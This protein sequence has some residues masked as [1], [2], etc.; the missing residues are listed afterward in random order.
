MVKIKD[1]DIEEIFLGVLQEDNNNK[2]EINKKTRYF[3]DSDW[4]VLSDL[5]VENGLF[6]VFYKR[7]LSLDLENTPPGL[8]SKLKTLYLVNLKRNIILERELFDIISYLQ[9]NNIPVIPLKGPTLAKFLYDDLSLRV[10]SCDLDLLIEQSKIKTAQKRLADKGYYFDPR[11]ETADFSYRFRRQIVLQRKIE[12]GGHMFLDLHWDFR[13]QFSHTHLQDFWLNAVNI[14]FDG[15][16]I[17]MPSP[18]DLL[19]YLILISISDFD[20]IQIKYLYDTHRLVTS[21]A[22]HI[23]WDALAVKANQAGLDTALFF[24]LQLSQELFN[25]RGIPKEILDSLKPSD[26]RYNLLR[27]WIN[28]RNILRSREKIS[29]GYAWR[30]FISSYALSKGIFD[31]M[32]IIYRKIFL[33]MDEV[34]GFYKQ[35][36]D[37]RSYFLYIKR[38]LKPITHLLKPEK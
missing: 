35:P 1:R 14:S 26:I 17:L 33:P 16:Q 6:P 9:E 21:F 15:H 7:L 19:L 18:E 37:K 28:K 25:A 11:H 3:K 10:I 29:R 36:L 34:M 13:D 32:P 12:G 31:C 20:F 5:S 24:S 30:Y 2:G 8:L 4:E 38:L 23:N 22:R 27:L